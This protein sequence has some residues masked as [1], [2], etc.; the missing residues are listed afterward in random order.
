MKVLIINSDYEYGSTGRIVKCIKNELDKTNHEC[1]ALYGRENTG[2]D[3]NV[4]RI[5][6]RFSVYWHV[7]RTR[8]EDRQGF[9]SFFATRKC[10]SIINQFEPDIIHLHNLHGSYIDCKELFEF[11]KQ[12]GIPVVWTL[13]DCWPYTGHCAYYSSAHCERWRTECYKCPQTR[14]YPKS[15]TDRSKWNY[16]KKK[17]VFS[18]C[19]NMH[20][21]TVSK[22]LKGEVEQ[23]FLREYPITVIPNGVDLDVFIPRDT[24]NLRNK[25]GIHNKKVMI[26][27]ASIWDSRKGLDLIYSVANKLNDDYI[28][29]VVGLDDVPKQLSNKVIAVPRTNSTTELSDLYSVADVF[30]NTSMEET[31]GLVTAEAL[32]CGKAVI[33]NHLTANPE[34]IDESCGVIVN[35]YDVEGYTSMITDSHVWELKSEDCRKRAGMFSLDSMINGY[36]SLYKS[37]V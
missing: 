24:T 34:L 21:T 22:W 26:S 36:L 20:L 11:L 17:E 37:I 2:S 6:S 32:A 12:S 23:S 16:T 9:S 25:L 31:F 33:T 8:V 18:C 5:G 3:K 30:V 4:Y 1:I 14:C 28:W 13:H 29:I 7:L 15:F 27:V 35:T 19:K 10:I